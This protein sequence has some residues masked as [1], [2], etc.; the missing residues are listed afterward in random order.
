M[1]RKKRVVN[2]TLKFPPYYRL[3][4][5]TIDLY[6]CPNCRSRA[7]PVRKSDGKLYLECL[8]I[9]NLNE[10]CEL[11]RCPDTLVTSINI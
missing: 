9:G 3:G 10:R 6:F 2:G 7:K 11:I 8:S 5:R 1:K 4:W